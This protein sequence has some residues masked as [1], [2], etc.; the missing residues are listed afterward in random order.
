MVEF[1]HFLVKQRWRAAAD[2]LIPSSTSG[3]EVFVVEMSLRT[4]VSTVIKIR[5]FLTEL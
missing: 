2:I 5:L 4:C 1:L 3:F